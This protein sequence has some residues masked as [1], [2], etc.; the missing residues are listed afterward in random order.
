MDANHVKA[1]VESNLTVLDDDTLMTI[2]DKATAELRRRGTIG[3]AP[4]NMS[5]R[6]QAALRKMSVKDLQESKPVAIEQ[7]MQDVRQAAQNGTL[8]Q[9]SNECPPLP[10]E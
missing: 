8:R 9:I 7:L 3:T 10:S 2:I 1:L 6:V 5:P 4:S